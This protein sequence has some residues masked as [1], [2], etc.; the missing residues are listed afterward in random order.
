MLQQSTRNTIR[1]TP[2]QRASAH[3]PMQN[4]VTS[5]SDA[6]T[7]AQAPLGGAAYR[8]EHRFDEAHVFK[9]P[10]PPFLVRPSHRP[11]TKGFDQKQA[12]VDP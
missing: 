9:P 2:Q 7:G 8:D 5:G 11:T 6:A 3:A 12:T 10:F 1:E 4:G